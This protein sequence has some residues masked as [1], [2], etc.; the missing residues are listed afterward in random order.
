MQHGEVVT[1]RM[2]R[3][4]TRE[5][6]P[7]IS[8]IT[9][10]NPGVVTTSSAH[11]FN[12]GDV[13]WHGLGDG[14]MPKLRAF[15]V[16]IIKIDATHYSIGIDTT[17]YGAFSAGPQAF[18][19]FAAPYISL[20]VGGRG[21]YPVMFKS[22]CNVIASAA[23]V[24]GNGAQIAIGDYKTFYFD[25]SFAGITNGTT[26]DWVTGTNG[27]NSGGCW[28]MQINSGAANSAEVG[29][30]IEHMVEFTNEV[31]EIS[32]A[33]GHCPS[34][35]WITIP[36]RGLITSNSADFDPDYTSGSDMPLVLTGKV[37]N[38]ANGFSGL[39]FNA[40]FWAELGNELWNGGSFPADYMTLRGYQRYNAGSFGSSINFYQ[41]RSVL[42]MKEIKA[43]FPGAKINYVLGGFSSGGTTVGSTNYIL[44]HG[45]A[46]YNGDA[47]NTWH[48]EPIADHDCLVV[49][50]YTDPNPAY[51]SGQFATDSALYAT[52]VP[53]NMTT[54]MNSLVTN[55]YVTPTVGSGNQLGSWYTA[56]TGKMPDLAAFMAAQGKMLCS[57]EGGLEADTF[58]GASLAGVHTITSADSV[59]LIASYRSSQWDIAQRTFWD[60][61][62][63]LAGHANPFVLLAMNNAPTIAPSNMR[64]AYATP[65][66][67]LG[68]V[69]GANL[70]AGA[71]WAGMAPAIGHFAVFRQIMDAFC[72]RHRHPAIC[73]HPI[74]KRVAPQT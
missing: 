47:I 27:T 48:T 73:V 1:C 6:A 60:G 8:N 63:L 52:G 9:N 71:V 69:E 22:Q 56:G 37:I 61:M 12:T 3:V 66:N 74:A 38:G 16:T 57:Y 4:I 50:P 7:G 51:C 68:G 17:T 19:P 35:C 49:A 13:I 21:A 2:N 65:D 29:F 53:A 20:N 72:C 11:G 32:T 67:Y 42:T 36:G 31:N 64:W 34:G 58:V 43:A 10:A 62:A 39:R 33:A 30:P 26:G 54:A 46:D 59:F 23:S 25:K 18:F 70:P 45:G 41:L 15:P 24:F 5:G 28:L 14:V 40:Y 44:C 55:G